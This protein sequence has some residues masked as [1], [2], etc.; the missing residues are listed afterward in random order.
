MT[1]LALRRVDPPSDCR[2]L[3]DWVTQERASF[4][5]MLDKSL[6][7]V[8]EIY[9]WID[10]QPHLAAYLMEVGSQPVAL[11]QTYDPQVDE[12]GQFYDRRPGDLGVHL[13]LA[14]TP[15]RE[16]RTREVVRFLLERLFADE[17]V[18]RIVFE[19][20]ARNARS[21]RLLGQFGVEAG[22][23]VQM[24]HKTAQFVFLHRQSL[25]RD[26]LS[27]AACHPGGR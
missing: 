14:D 7:E 3:H 1:D 13:L 8:E 15:A 17:E 24:P 25:T 22:P 4:W 27:R 9:T 19:P 2:L 26:S 18:R 20:D 16:G 5:G 21:L 10:E 12:I 23:R 11:F 6:D